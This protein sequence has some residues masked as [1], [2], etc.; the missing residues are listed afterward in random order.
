MFHM[1]QRKLGEKKAKQVLDILSS[2]ENSKKFGFIKIT[3][4]EL[5]ELVSLYSPIGMPLHQDVFTFR[6][7]VWMVVIVSRGEYVE[8][9]LL[10]PYDP[11]E[12]FIAVE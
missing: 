1:F 3:K 9:T 2:A 5:A 4:E 11:Q 10:N 8:V 6:A 12:H 7:G